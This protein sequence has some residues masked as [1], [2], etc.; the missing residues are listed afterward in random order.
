M[1]PEDDEDEI[2]AHLM[3]SHLEE[4]QESIKNLQT[5]QFKSRFN[6][7]SPE[8]FVK[9]MG[10]C[11]SRS[12][13]ISTSVSKSWNQSILGAT[14]LFRHFQMEGKV[15]NITK[16]IE[17]F[18]RRS[19]NS[20]RSIELKIKDR[21]NATEQKQLQDAISPSYESLRWLSI[22]HQGELG[23]LSIDIASECPHLLFLSSIVNE[24][25]FSYPQE[26]SDQ[27]EIPPSF[28][29]KL[30]DFVWDNP[31]CNLICNEH[32][33]QCLQGAKGISL[34]CSGPQPAWVIRLLTSTSSTL[35]TV[36]LPFMS[37]GSVEE[38]P[39]LDLPNW[40]F[41]FWPMLQNQQREIRASSS[42]NFKLR[43]LL[44]YKSTESLQKRFLFSDKIPLL[45]HSRHN[46]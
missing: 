7:L 30:E 39:P 43:T 26:G 29:P 2:H 19:N 3:D 11:D 41:C 5:H 34:G 17:I 6:R 32:L 4:L 15:S 37:T 9:M 31:E 42:N 18:E 46:P 28:K 33:L 35:I 12:L 14:D 13:M 36:I 44:T 21:A 10:F 45:K 8:L 24:E 38:I 23:R 16:G 20:I 40:N 22:V 25:R 27:L 1:I